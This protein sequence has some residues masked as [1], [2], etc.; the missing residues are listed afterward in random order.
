MNAIQLEFFDTD[1]DILHKDIKENHV[2]I[3]NV[4][5]GLFKRV[6]SIC[7][8]VNFLK[9]EILDLKTEMQLLINVICDDG[10]LTDCVIEN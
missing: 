6:N 1:I 10:N 4:R 8:E 9:Q 2:R 3:E 7:D 5:R